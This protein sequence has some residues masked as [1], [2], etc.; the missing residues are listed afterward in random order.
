MELNLLHQ[1]LAEHHILLQK[2]ANNQSQ[3]ENEKLRIMFYHNR[4]K[5][6]AIGIVIGLI[7]VSLASSLS[8]DNV[9]V[10]MLCFI[11]SILA[12]THLLGPMLDSKRRQQL[13]AAARERLRPLVL[14]MGEVAMKME[15]ANVLPEKYRTL[16]AVSHLME[17]IENRRIDTLKEGL[18]LYENDLKSYDQQKGFNR[19]ASQQEKMIT[20]QKTMTEQQRQMVRAQQ[21]T[22]NLLVWFR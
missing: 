17:Y 13:K 10:V 11:G 3:I 16:H 14:E 21:T 7:A 22:N 18:N 19:L 9:V 6:L 4:G 12:M 1:H 15:Q 2:Y 20:Q 5:H 8:I